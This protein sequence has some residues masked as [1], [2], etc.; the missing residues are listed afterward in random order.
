MK[1]N[2]LKIGLLSFFVVL[3]LSCNAPRIVY[4]YDKEIDFTQYKT[5]DYYPDM[6][7]N[8]SELDSARIVRQVDNILTAKGFTQSQTP[9]VYIN[10]ISEQYKTSSNSNVGL[11]VGGTGHNIGFGISGGIPLQ[12][13]GISLYL[14]VDMIDANKNMQIWQSVYEGSYRMNMSPDRKNAYFNDVFTRIF[15]GYPPE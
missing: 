1:N 5:F 15:N 2:I 13:N 3:F 6:Q 8:L 12:S 4:D 9:D 10:I 7:L 11:G 14:T